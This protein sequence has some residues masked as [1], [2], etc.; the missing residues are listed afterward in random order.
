MANTVEVPE[1]FKKMDRAKSYGE[2]HPPLDG[3]FFEQNGLMYDHRGEILTS[4]ITT[5]QAA[6]LEKENARERARAKAEEAYRKALESEGIEDDEDG[7]TVVVAKEKRTTKAK[8]TKVGKVEKP[9]DDGELDLRGWAKGEV[10]IPFD[11]VQKA[12][13]GTFGKQVD[14][15]AD[16]VDAVGEALKIPADQLMNVPVMAPAR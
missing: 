12:I 16:A 6:A 1:R 8:E 9:S 11:Q 2:I 3:A 10:K 13:R 7:G 15:L 5:E 4:A 14:T